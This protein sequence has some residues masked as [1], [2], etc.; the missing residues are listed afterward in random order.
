MGTAH[1]DVIFKFVILVGVVMVG[2]GVASAYQGHSVLVSVR[3]PPSAF[4]GIPEL[5]IG[6]VMV[7]VGTAASRAINKR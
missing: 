3:Q 6:V 7:A 5:I 2:F 1:M 4:A